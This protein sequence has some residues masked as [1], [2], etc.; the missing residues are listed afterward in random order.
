MCRLVQVCGNNHSPP[1]Y[2]IELVSCNWWPQRPNGRIQVPDSG[3]VKIGYSLWNER[4]Y[5]SVWYLSGVRSRCT[6]EV[7]LVVY[8]G[9]T[10]ASHWCISYWSRLQRKHVS[11]FRGVLKL[12]PTLDVGCWLTIAVGCCISHGSNTISTVCSQH[13]A[14]ATSYKWNFQLMK[15]ST[16]RLI[17]LMV[18]SWRALASKPIPHGGKLTCDSAESY[19]MK[20][21]TKQIRLLKT[22]YIL[23]YPSWP[24]YTKSSSECSKPRAWSV[25]CIT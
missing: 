1:V 20:R 11:W 3:E 5:D 13:S 10:T 21:S 4:K 23:E 24:E 12:C 22:S 7:I 16:L 18:P 17:R 25:F 8:F 14:H 9:N 15:L 19:N 6:L 2:E